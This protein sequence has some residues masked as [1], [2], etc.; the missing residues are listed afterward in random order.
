MPSVNFFLEDIN[1]RVRKKKLIRNWLL[2]TIKKEGGELDNINLIFTSDN[3]LHHINVEHL[4]HDTLTDIITFEYNETGEPITSDIFI[5][6]DRVKENSVTFRQRQLDE[7]HRIIVHGTLHLLGYK[8]KNK[9][10]KE[11]MTIKEDYYLS[12]RSE[13]LLNY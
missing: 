10:D 13:D 8:D 11:L 5:S 9:S 1:F 4:N 6:V 12:L 2:L 7:L 3:Y